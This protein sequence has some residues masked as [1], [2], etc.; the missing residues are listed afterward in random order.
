MIERLA[1][2]LADSP[3]DA[4]GWR[5]LARSYSVVGRFAE[6]SNAYARA[7]ELTPN[8][9]QLLAD[10][11]DVLGA[12]QGHKLD[13]KPEKLVARALEID[14]DNAKAL[15]LAG[16]IAFDRKD[17]RLAVS[18]WERIVRTAP[19]E[20]DFARSIRGS[21]AEA[22]AL[23]NQAAPAPTRSASISAASPTH[24][25]SGVVRLAPHL[26]GKVTP[27]DTVFVY[28][29][30]AEGPRVPLAVMR[31]SARELPLDFKL[32]DAM[33]MDPSLKLSAFEKIVVSARISKSGNA[34]PQPGD[35]YGRTDPISN[36]ASAVTVLIDSETR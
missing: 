24:G 10:Y 4:N 34:Q 28:A 21:I 25:L 6:A 23:A 13:G 18:H 19:A 22:Q 30:A 35:L 15:A 5:M 3:D 36:S 2:R 17:Y 31:A 9:A 12:V 26:T 32:D 14:P 1:V 16:T 33:A 11:A 20:S 29:R 27:A 7:V 8:D